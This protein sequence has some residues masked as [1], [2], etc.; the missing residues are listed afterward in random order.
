MERD[1]SEETQEILEG[2]IACT[3]ERYRQKASAPDQSEGA[4]LKAETLASRF[5]DLL[6]DLR[7]GGIKLSSPS[8]VEEYIRR[9]RAS[10]EVEDGLPPDF[11]G[12]ESKVLGRAFAICPGNPPRLYYPTLEE[13]GRGILYEL[14][15]AEVNPDP[16]L[17]RGRSA[18]LVQEALDSLSRKIPLVIG[19]DYP[20]TYSLGQTLRVIGWNPAFRDLSAGDLVAILRREEAGVQILTQMLAEHAFA[21]NSEIKWQKHRRGAE[22]VKQV[23]VPISDDRHT[24]SANDGLGPDDVRAVAA[25]LMRKKPDVWR[26][27]GLIIT[28]GQWQLL[29]ALE[30]SVGIDPENGPSKELCKRL[31]TLLGSHT[32]ELEEALGKIFAG[33]GVSEVRRYLTVH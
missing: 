10:R 17:A 7:S 15:V 8:E 9:Q 14:I 19:R 16:I 3:V 21:I 25:L 29:Q 33:R 31:G 30:G 26:K 2:I 27:D 4:A 22:D 32:S 11:E 23:S 13:I 24:I 6:E 12:Y 20:P 28:E 5:V 1:T 18:E